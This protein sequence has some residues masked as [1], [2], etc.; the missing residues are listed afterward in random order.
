MVDLE[1]KWVIYLSRFFL[2]YFLLFFPTFVDS[3]PV[4]VSWVRFANE[5]LIAFFI[6]SCLLS[7]FT[8]ESFWT[9]LLETKKCPRA[10]RHQG[11]LTTY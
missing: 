5:F 11:G 1:K 10:G 3:I 7:V 2:L 9:R 6:V 4:F 8:P